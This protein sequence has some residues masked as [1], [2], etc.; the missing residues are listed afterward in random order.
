MREDSENGVRLTGLLVGFHIF[1]DLDRCGWAGN[2]VV[3]F[4]I[5]MIV[6]VLKKDVDG[7]KPL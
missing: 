5:V 4:Q 1:I 3:D 2:F 6:V 7:Q